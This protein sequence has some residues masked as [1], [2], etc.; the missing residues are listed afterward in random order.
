MRPGPITPI[1]KVL[2]TPNHWKARW[3][4][5]RQP[6]P[7]LRF[8][9]TPSLVANDGTGLGLGTTNLRGPI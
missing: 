6:I 4:E 5:I 8:T 9:L 1:V 3:G 2:T 7:T